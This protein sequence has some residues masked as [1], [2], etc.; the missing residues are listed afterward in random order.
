MKFKT[1]LTQILFLVFYSAFANNGRYRLI[2]VDDPSTTITIAWD[3]SSGTS[4]VVY[5]GTLDE[6][7][8]YLNYPNSKTVDRVVVDKDMDNTFARLTGLSANTNYYFV[9]NDS[10]GTSQRFWFR[11]APNDNSRLSIIAGGD[12][13]NFRTPRRAANLLVSKLKP[14][15]VLFAGDMTDNSTD[16]EWKKWFDDWQDTIAS[17]GR[18][19]PIIPARGNHENATDIYDLFDTPNTNSYYALT[20]GNSL[21]RAYTLNSEISVFGN[22]LT[23][24]QNDLSA[25]SGVIWKMAQYHKPIR[26]HT[27]WKAE[28]NNQY[29]AWAQLF[30]DEG[31]RLVVDCDSHVART[32]WPLKPSSELGNDEGFVVEQTNGTVYTGEGCWGAPL[33]PN[34]DD[35]SWTRNSGSFNQFKLLFVEPSKIE[36]RT[37]KVDNAMDVGEVSNTD[38]FTLPSMLD[39]FSPPTGDVVIISN[40]N[41]IFCPV[42]YSP[43]DDEDSDTVLDE[44]DGFCNCQGFDS[45]DNTVFTTQVLYSSDDAEEITG[46]VN[47]SSSDLELVTDSD[48]QLVGLRFDGIEIPE[49]A[50]ILR[51]YIQFS[52]DERI[53]PQPTT[54]LVI[55]GELSP[56]SNTFS[57]TNKISTR[58]LTTNSTS[59]DDV[60]DWGSIDIAGANQRSPD[61]S[62]EMNEI[63]AQ[64]GWVNGNAVAFIISGTGKRVADSYDDG[65]PPK[66]I[67][68]FDTDCPLNDIEIGAIS[69]CDEMTDT[70]SQDVIVTYQ[71]APV[72]GTLNV[73]GQAFAIGTSPQT[74]TLTGLSANGFDVDI[75]AVFSDV[76]TCT[77]YKE[78]IYEAPSACSNG[79]LPNNI[80]NDN[81]NIALLPDATVSGNV[82]NGRGVPE[83]ILYDPSI[84]NYYTVTA[85][86]EYGLALNKDIGSPVD[87]DKGMKWQVNWTNVKYINYITFGG[88]YTFNSQGQPNTLWRISYRVD[89]TWIILEEG[90]GG[91]IDGGI[92]EWGGTS[93]NPIEA[94]A[95]RVQLYS[96]GFNE[97]KSTHLRGR[98]GIS[99]S[100]DDSST[101]TKATLIQY[102]SPGN[103]CSVAIPS[104]SILYCDGDWINTD[105]P[106]ET[107]GSIDTIIASGIYIIDAD[108]DVEVNDLEISIGATVIIKEG[109]SLTIKGNFIN[110]GI[111]E[112]E[113][114]STKYSSLIVDGT[115]TGNVS[116]KRHVNAFNG[117]TGNDLVSSPFSGQTF[118]AF[119]T[120]NPNLFENPGNTVQKLFGPFN[121]LSGSYETYLTTTNAAT[122][123]EKGNGYRAARDASEDGTSGTTLTFT[124]NVETSAVNVPIVAGGASNWNLIGNPYPSYLKVQDFLNFMANSGLIDENAVGIYGYDGAAADSWTIYNLATTTASTVITPG[125]G[126]FIDAEAS[127]NMSFTPSMRSKGSDD[128]FILGRNSNILTYL[129]L[130]ASANNKTYHTDFYFN[131]NASLG[132]DPGYDAAVW[133]ESPPSFAVYSNLVQENTGVPLALQA[134]NDNDLSNVVIPLGVNAN[135][136]E[137]LT[138]SILESTIPNSVDVYLEDTITN[139]FTLLNSSNYT[140]TP[141]SAISGIGRFY[142]RF[143]VSILNTVEQPLESLSIYADS[144]QKTIVIDGQLLS[145]TGF[146]LYDISGRVVSFIPLDITSTKQSINIA[147]LST[148]IYIV[149]LISDT[150]E[151]RI[152]KLIIK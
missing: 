45:Y 91:W 38:P 9:I 131:P 71:N 129:K 94:D 12:S 61:L 118:G 152:E 84:G 82:V 27:A 136:N 100:F 40:S 62:D 97:V 20:F 30:Y 64:P 48:V 103:A 115:S 36:L 23:W 113:S 121:E 96:D 93:F 104:G 39:V 14:H 144:K 42:V 21:F 5:Y 108:K 148:G 102:L 145:D 128:D 67:V 150:N 83:E 112:L 142:L 130:N 3:Q 132:L 75:T 34:D 81:L 63:F 32:T 49:S 47:T 68:L 65:K 41:D 52:I 18:M 127:G 78:S 149:E 114:T 95:L 77:I 54:N 87:P 28:N 105:G 10:E 101:T 66:L 98:G 133:Y 106:D 139:T 46:T 43:C 124:G 15:A 119:A 2:L 59:W 151:K 60:A 56:D 138:F 107:S 73:N 89:G 13:R 31:V 126:F 146:K 141:S 86:N 22:Q 11:T 6:G 90:T 26:P 25:S 72:T 57:N 8:N 76:P 29:D 74:V 69:A 70:Y 140:L 1:F 99:T 35:K 117:S 116:Y 16:L 109:A 110:N 37:I 17:D 123:L 80:P 50:T 135:A 33:R 122:L 134:L 4:P 53:T 111:I 147:Q 44:E 19:F 125:Q 55:H 79:G 92:Y 137:A 7:T 88:V 51:A 120:N 85:F 24:L 143:E 58:T